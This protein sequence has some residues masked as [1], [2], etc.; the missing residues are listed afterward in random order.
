MQSLAPHGWAWAFWTCG[1]CCILLLSRAAAG[2]D[3]SD[4]DAGIV[5][6][7]VADEGAGTEPLATTQ[8]RNDVGAL[9]ESSPVK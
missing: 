4:G 6:S 5:G 2:V 9:E 7:D 8:W 3:T 1:W